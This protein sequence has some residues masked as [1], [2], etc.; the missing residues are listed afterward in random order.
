M[1]R[2][3]CVIF[4][5]SKTDKKKKKKRKGK[6]SAGKKKPLAAGVSDKDV[7]KM[8]EEELVR[9]YRELSQMV[10]NRNKTHVTFQRRV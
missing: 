5:R 7:E 2:R 6:K 1:T 10:D 3:N 9:E 4:R 8:D